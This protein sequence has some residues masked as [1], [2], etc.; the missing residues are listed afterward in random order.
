MPG[1]RMGFF[2]TS[3]GLVN[4]TYYAFQKAARL[5]GSNHVDL[6]SRL[7]HAASVVGPQGHARRP[8]AHLLAQG[9]DRLGPGG[10]PGLAPRQQPA[11]HHQVPVLRQAPGH[12]HRGGESDARAGARALLGAERPAQRAVRHEADGRFLPGRGGRRHRVPPRRD[13]APDRARLD[14]SRV[15]RA[16]APAASTSYARVAGARVGAARDRPAGLAR[17][18]ML[19][20]AET[21]ARAKTAVFVYSMG[22]TQHRFG[23]DNVKRAGEPGARARHAGAREVRHH[24]DPRALRRPGRR[25]V[26]RRSRQVSRRLRGRERPATARRFETLWGAP[27]PAW[28]GHRTLQMLEAAHAWRDRLPLLAR[29]QPARDR[30]RIAPTWREALSGVR[31]PHPSGHRAQHLVAAARDAPCCCCRRDDA[32]RRWAAARSPAP[33]AASASRPRSRAAHRRGAPGVSGSRCWSR[34]PARP[35]LA[36]R[37]SHGRRT[38]DIRQRDG[39]GDA[40]V[41]RHREARH[42]RASRVQWGGERLF[43]D[44]FTKHA[45]RACALHRTAGAEV[46]IPPGNVLPDHAAR[47][48]V[49]QHGLRSTRL[50]PGGQPD[51]NRC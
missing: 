44:G 21:Y 36:P 23:V 12:A 27:L 19:R 5:M 2:A 37:R 15:R 14:R 9:H 47:Q 26:R 34:A 3:R 50:L 22:L 20:F 18:D 30:C 49:Q 7:C 10:D 35:A 33:S 31:L 13:E 16:R 11:G 45:R 17:A 48:A 38:A 40:D 25:R 43:T 32:T 39:A 41:R 28:K 29:R 4:E 42:A 8:G 1:E 51:V 46:E 24:A 6:C